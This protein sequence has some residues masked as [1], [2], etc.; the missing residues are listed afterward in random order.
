MSWFEV[1]LKHWSRLSEE[2][3]EKVREYYHLRTVAQQL[4]G[5]FLPARVQQLEQELQAE[6]H[7]LGWTG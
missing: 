1:L 3:Q 5:Q 7:K 2:V 6:A 4:G